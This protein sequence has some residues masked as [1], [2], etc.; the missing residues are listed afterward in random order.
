MIAIGLKKRIDRLESVLNHLASWKDAREAGRITLKPG[1]MLAALLDTV[2]V[3]FTPL[4]VAPVEH[5]LSVCLAWPEVIEGETPLIREMATNLVELGSLSIEQQVEYFHE[6]FGLDFHPMQIVPPLPSPDDSDESDV[7]S[8]KAAVATQYLTAK[9]SAS[10]GGNSTGGNSKSA[11]KARAPAK[12][13]PAQQKKQHRKAIQKERAAQRGRLA[14]KQ[15]Q[16]KLEKKKA[17]NK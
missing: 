13:S 14:E 9:A 8:M 4:S 10:K 2:A 5:L 1:V 17:R 3:T 12:P 7:L 6:G 11:G 16:V 15:K